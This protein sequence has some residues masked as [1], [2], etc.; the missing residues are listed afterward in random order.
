M[1]CKKRD[2]LVDTPLHLPPQTSTQF[3]S[4]W[5]PTF[6]CYLKRPIHPPP[7]TMLATKVF[8]LLIYSK[9][10]RFLSCL[11]VVFKSHSRSL[12][13]IPS[14]LPTLELLT[15]VNHVVFFA[16]FVL[17]TISVFPLRCIISEWSSIF[18]EVLLGNIL[19]KAGQQ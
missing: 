3:V 17:G 13:P 16:H 11:N 15:T 18:L 8:W 2:M 6:S 10:W 5:R 4:P 9:P 7:N 19:F 12:A 1:S 14:L